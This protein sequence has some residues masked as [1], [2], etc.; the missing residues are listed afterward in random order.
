MVVTLPAHAT[1]EAA[2]PPQANY[3]K[4]WYGPTL[5]ILYGSAYVV[6]GGGVFI[7]RRA[8]SVFARAGGSILVGAAALTPFAGAPITH[9]RHDNFAGGLISMGGQLGTSVAGG[10][11]GAGVGAA[12]GKDRLSPSILL[13]AL[14]GHMTW[15]LVDI[16]AL[17][18][19]ERLLSIE[20]SAQLEPRIWM[21]SDG[22]TLGI[23]ARL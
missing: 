4:L 18:R 13:G 23:S 2:D 21:S 11:I 22:F 16:F 1:G 19:H 10:A 8:D 6:G 3:E 17:A 7:L 5:A 9:W 20:T 15:A 12:A 14:G